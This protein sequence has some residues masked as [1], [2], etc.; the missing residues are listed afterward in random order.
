MVRAFII[1]SRNYLTILN[2]RLVDVLPFLKDYPDWL[3]GSSFKRV[4]C[5]WASTLNEMVEMP[6]AFVKKQMVTFYLETSYK[7]T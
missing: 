6:H 4:A 7:Q 5:E 1:S 3:P 2:R